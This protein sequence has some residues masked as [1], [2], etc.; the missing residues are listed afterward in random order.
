MPFWAGANVAFELGYT[1]LAALVDHMSLEINK[2]TCAMLILLGSFRVWQG[3]EFPSMI[4]EP[5][6]FCIL[7]QCVAW[8]VLWVILSYLCLALTLCF[9]QTL[10]HGA[11]WSGSGG[12]GCWDMN[13]PTFLSSAMAW[14]GWD[15]GDWGETVDLMGK[16]ILFTYFKYF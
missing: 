8:L 5:G 10:L 12:M 16:F 6:G 2:R 7:L 11:A 14:H 4:G 13:G 1:L 15:W 9:Q 3:W